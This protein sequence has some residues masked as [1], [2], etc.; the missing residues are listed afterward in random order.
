[1]ITIID[2]R[3][4]NLGSLQ[5]AFELV[6]I[7]S[8]VSSNPNEVSEARSLVLPGV[9]AFGQ[10]MDNLRACELDRA[11]RSAVENGAW[12]LG[13]CLGMQLLSDSSDEHGN[14]EGLGLI[15]GTVTRLQGASGFLRVPNIG[16]RTVNW[17]EGSQLAP[18]WTSTPN[19]YFVHSF[20]MVPENQG[21]GVGYMPFGSRN[22]TVAAREGRVLGVQF[23]PE[24]S[25][26]AGMFLLARFNEMARE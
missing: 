8:K 6:G 14:H 3:I 19:Y 16:W 11:I 2:S 25:Q 17:A 4:A 13:I 1:M 10:A 20:H 12:L 22:I 24:K 18:P 23:H 15:P 9:G 21:H 5:R 7:E 26:A